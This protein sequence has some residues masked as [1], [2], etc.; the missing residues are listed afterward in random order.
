[1]ENIIDLTNDDDEVFQQLEQNG[2]DFPRESIS[3]LPTTFYNAPIV[4]HLLHY[5]NIGKSADFDFTK[6]DFTYICGIL[7]SSFELMYDVDLKDY[8]RGP[9]IPCALAYTYHENI[10]FASKQAEQFPTAI[11]SMFAVLEIIEKYLTKHIKTSKNKDPEILI[12]FKKKI[13]DHFRNRKAQ[14]TGLFPSIRIVSF[15]QRQ[16]NTHNT[17]LFFNQLLFIILGQTTKTTQK[18]E[19]F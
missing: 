14:K 15:F 7:A 19:V 16:I 18:Y 17:F 4:T 13:Q 5:G 10:T 1:M 2:W 6:K 11:I 9:D 3:Q 8:L 12:D